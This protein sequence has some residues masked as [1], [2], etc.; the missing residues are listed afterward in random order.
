MRVVKT[1]QSHP[2]FTAPSL[3]HCCLRTSLHPFPHLLM[4]RLLL[5]RCYILP[6]CPSTAPLQGGLCFGRVAQQYP[7]ARCEPKSLIELRNA[8]TPIFLPSRRSSLGSNVGD[9][10]TTLDAFEVFDTTYVGRLTSPLFT[11]EHE[12]SGTPYGF[13]CSQTHSSVEKS[14]RDVEPF[15]SFGKLLSKCQR[16]QDMERVQDSQ[17][18]RKNSFREQISIHHVIEKES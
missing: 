4:D 1:I 7:L 5:L 11:L 9:L 16:I 14:R 17:Q 13:S 8:H 18:E 3:T 2:C 15:L 12:V 6:M 10:P